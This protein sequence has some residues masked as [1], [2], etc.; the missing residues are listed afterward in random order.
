MRD[1]DQVPLNDP[2]FRDI[3]FDEE[4]AESAIEESECFAD[5]RPLE[6]MQARCRKWSM[7]LDTLAD[8]TGRWTLMRER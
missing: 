3:P 4:V 5:Q 8:G 1:L 7:L 2:I 6:E